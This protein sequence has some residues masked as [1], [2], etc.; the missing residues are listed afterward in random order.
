MQTKHSFSCLQRWPY[1]FLAEKCKCHTVVT[2]IRTAMVLQAE[3]WFGTSLLLPK[4]KGHPSP[5]AEMSPSAAL[6]QR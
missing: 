3:L 6:V 1:C 5:G 4:T 2:L